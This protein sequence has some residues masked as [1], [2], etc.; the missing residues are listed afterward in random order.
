M[1]RHGEIADRHRT[2]GRR[3][4]REQRGPSA[5][6]RLAGQP[7]GDPAHQQKGERCEQR[8]ACPGRVD[9]AERGQE[10]RESGPVSRYHLPGLER[11]VQEIVAVER[12]DQPGHQVRR[13]Q[14]RDVSGCKYPALE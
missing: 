5:R 4:E 9:E 13:K 2:E 12:R 3:A 1:R 8:I 14:A 6:L 7:D 11:S 10:E